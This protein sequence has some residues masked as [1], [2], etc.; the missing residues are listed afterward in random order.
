MSVKTILLSAYQAIQKWP[1]KRLIKALEILKAK[2]LVLE[3]ENQRLE[4]E[5]TRLKKE[6]EKQKIAEINKN[7]NKPSSKQPEWEERQRGA[8]RRR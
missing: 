4:T 6:L 8:E 2:Y 1:K 5:N 7:T 3:T